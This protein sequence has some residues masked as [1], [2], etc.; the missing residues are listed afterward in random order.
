M[1]F[2]PE[3]RQWHAG[4][5]S[6][7]HL[8]TSALPDEPQTRLQADGV[9]GPGAAMHPIS[10]VQT[11]HECSGMT[12][13]ELSGQP[14]AGPHANG[15]MRASAEPQ[16]RK[17]AERPQAHAVSRSSCEGA[18]PIATQLPASDSSLPRCASPAVSAGND[19][20]RLSDLTPAALLVGSDATLSTEPTPMSQ[21][22]GQSQQRA[23][24]S[25]APVD[26]AA[27]DGMSQSR[28]SDDGDHCQG[29]SASPASEHLTTDDRA[30]LAALDDQPSSPPPRLLSLAGISLKSPS[31]HEVRA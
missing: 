13:Q 3:L 1:P 10:V 31:L 15:D 25:T 23:R 18:D 26:S 17:V 7:Q 27:R 9:N 6:G 28:A 19:T 21:P 11:A 5:R 29:S 24:A 8:F 12:G 16:H 30:A 14:E 2:R 4:H 22:N 20:S